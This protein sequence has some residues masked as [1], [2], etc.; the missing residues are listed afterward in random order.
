M[1]F[2]GDEINLICNARDAYDIAK[3]YLKGLHQVS[4]K[5]STEP[6][7]ACAGIAIFHSHAP[8]AQA[9]KIAEECCES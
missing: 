5:D 2:A 3:T 4:W 8:Y 7:S 6:C 1:V 9:Y